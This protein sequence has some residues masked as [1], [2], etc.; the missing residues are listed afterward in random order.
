MT[1][2]E[3]PTDPETRQRTVPGLGARRL[4][5]AVVSLQG[6]ALVALA[7]AEALHISGDRL[8]LGAATAIFFL[9]YGA[10]LV[11]AGIGLNAGHGWARGPALM[12]QFIQLG[13]AWNTRAE[14]QYAVPLLAIAL[15]ALAALVSATRADLEDED[16]AG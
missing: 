6:S 12:T 9:G 8:S 13:L 15:I 3:E 14:P 4:G 2:P 11:A 1:T 7:V 10:L 16:P 5:A